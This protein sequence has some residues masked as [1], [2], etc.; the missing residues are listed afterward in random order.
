[1]HLYYWGPLGNARVHIRVHIG[2]RTI[3]KGWRRRRVNL[4]GHNGSDWHSP[5]F[6]ARIGAAWSASATKAGSASS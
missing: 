1:M 6:E 3:E 2:H 5:V 4:G